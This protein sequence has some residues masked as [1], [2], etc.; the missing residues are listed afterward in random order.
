MARNGTAQE[1]AQALAEV[2][3][4]PNVPDRNLE[5]ANLV[6]TTDRI[7]TALFAVADALHDVARAVREREDRGAA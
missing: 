7:G 1:I 6:D 3:I 5:P 2:L 4:S